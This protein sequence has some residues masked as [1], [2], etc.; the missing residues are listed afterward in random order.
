MKI[1]IC[2]IFPKIYSLGNRF[3]GIVTIITIE[4]QLL[5]RWFLTKNHAAVYTAACLKDSL[6][7]FAIILFRTVWKTSSML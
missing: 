5:G 7:Y 2:T 6:D 4:F 1:P 3:Y